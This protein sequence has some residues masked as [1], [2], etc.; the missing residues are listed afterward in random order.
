MRKVV[1]AAAVALFLGGCA[2]SA[3]SLYSG[4]HSITTT[5]KP[6]TT[7]TSTSTT[8]TTTPKCSTATTPSGG[9]TLTVCPGK[10]PV[11][12]TV[13]V[14]A[15]GC[16]FVSSLVFLGPLAFVGSSG[17][18][19]Q[20]NHGSL[21]SSGSFTL[22]YVIPSSYTTGGNVNVGIPVTAGTNYRFSSYPRACSAPFTVSGPSGTSQ[23][24]YQPFTASG[25]DPS[26]HVTATTSGDCESYQAAVG[27]QT[28]FRCFATGETILDPCLAGPRGAKAG[29]VLACPGD[30]TSPDITTVT[31]TSVSPEGSNL[32]VIEPWAMEL[33]SGQTCRFVSAA[34][35]RSGPYS[36]AA[37]KGKS[38][39]ADCRVPQP[40]A[41]WW[42][43]SCQTELSDSSP[44]TPTT[45][46]KV[47]F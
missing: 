37:P 29:A 25:L 11:G 21:G 26:L 20:I 44:F 32:Q 45:T 13:T 34:W 41:P 7:P 18:G 6:T 27:S 23:I 16:H 14:S 15:S 43:T 3:R 22:R 19:D 36:C 8:T 30:P 38:G 31:F 10:A 35:G 24:V 12:A 47:W 1:V 40:A 33:A 28:Y 42:T 9:G 46:T 39:V 17:G 2:S 4:A 5:S